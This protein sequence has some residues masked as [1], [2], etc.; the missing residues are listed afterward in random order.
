MTA[1]TAA[2]LGVVA[3]LTSV[4]AAAISKQ[5]ADLF[6]RKVAQIVVQGDSV[7]KPGTK[8][9]QVSESELNSWFAYSAK[10][11]LPAGVT[12]PRITLVGRGKVAGQ[13]VV[14]LDA[15]AKRKQSGGTFDVWNLVGGKVPV[16]VAGTL[17]TKDG[18]GT[19]LVES[20]DVSGLPLPKSFLQEVVS[21]YSRTPAH[22]QG[23]KI[24]DPFE[25]PASIRQ[26]DVGAGQAVIV[27]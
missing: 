3:A 6:S 16:N 9:T 4:E 18:I 7:Q 8:K 17:Q 19:F 15:I 24:D 23:V 27:Q 26:I 5:Q 1:R 22:P 12:D 21:Y 2:I 11:L 25:L 20:A 10:P 14:D 13:A